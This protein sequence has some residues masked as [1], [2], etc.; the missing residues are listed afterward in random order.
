MVALTGS[1]DFAD[2]PAAIDPSRPIELAI[3]DARTHAPN[4]PSPHLGI[5]ADLRVIY[6]VERQSLIE[7]L[8]LL[9]DRRVTSLLGHEKNGG[10]DTDELI[11][12]CIRSQRSATAELSTYLAWGATSMSA[13]VRNHAE[14]RHA[15]EALAQYAGA[16]GL[17][18]S[19]RDRI[20][21]AA[22]EL[23]MNALWHAPVDEGGN[24]L[25]GS[26]P[27][28]E[29]A[30]LAEVAPIEV[31]FGLC[32][33][34][35][36]VAVRDGKGSLTRERLLE[37]LLRARDGTRIEEKK[38]GAGLGLITVLRSASRL[39][40]HL[41]H[42]TGTCV[43]ALFDLDLVHAGQGPRSVHV[44]EAEP[45][46]DA[47]ED[48]PG[49]P[50]E[51]SAP[52]Q[53]HLWALCAVLLALVSAMATAAVLKHWPT[54]QAATVTVLVEPDDATVTLD[55]AAIRAGEPAPVDEGWLQVTR[56]GFQPKALKVAKDGR[57]HVVH[58]VLAP[59]SP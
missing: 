19:M 28:K 33:H 56:P 52:S 44:F 55:G 27:R 5:H 57:S 41:D 6:V 26:I 23:M 18:G 59:G 48:P 54:A 21:L 53:L 13:I 1:A 14:K 51:P 12:A 40:F 25:Y 58:V 47:S 38:S 17:R 3:F 46:R 20:Q 4:E 8:S 11:G 50:Q 22:D 15:L 42:G 45:R 49:E 37:Y 10:F 29:L 30:Q 24:E 9:S 32:G 36:G 39:A 35:F 2:S 31:A 43:V 34:S 7:Q 16:A